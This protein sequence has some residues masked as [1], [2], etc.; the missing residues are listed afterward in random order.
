MTTPARN[1][2][3]AAAPKPQTLVVENTLKCQ[4]ADGGEV[5]LSL[6]LPYS[7]L[8][9]LLTMEG[10][11]MPEED[12]VDYVI[13]EIMPPETAAVINGLQ[14]GV[15][16]IIFTLKWLDA[17]GERLNSLGKAGPSSKS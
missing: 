14:D 4:T 17:L 12:L 6:L 15:D 3:K 5:S 10:Q 2:P 1:R 7:N 16:T 11:E 8:K 9:L 13:T